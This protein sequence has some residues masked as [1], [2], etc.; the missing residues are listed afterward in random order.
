MPSLES[1]DGQP[2]LR[3]LVNPTVGPVDLEQVR[4]TFLAALGS[5]SGAKRM[6]ALQWRQGGVAPGGVA[7]AAGDRHRQDPRDSPRPYGRIGRLP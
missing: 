4:D 6:A 1:A 7:R 5:G 2:L 3:L